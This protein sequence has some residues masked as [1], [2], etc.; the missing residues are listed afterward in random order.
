M[1]HPGGTPATST[2]RREVLSFRMVELTQV[3]ERLGLKKTGER[4]R[5]LRAPPLPPAFLGA[6]RA[7]PPVSMPP[8]PHAFAVPWRCRA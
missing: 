6:L 5:G 3:A 4:R 2:V 7:L 1:S 8:G